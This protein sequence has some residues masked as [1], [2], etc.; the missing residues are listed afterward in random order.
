MADAPVSIVIP[1]FN[2][3]AYCQACVASLRRCTPRPVK[4]ILVDNGSTDGVGPFFDSVAGAEAV[5]AL[6]NR[7]FAGGVNLGLER[8]E[9]HVVLLNSDTLLTPGWLDRL[10]SALLSAPDIGVAGPMSNC[11]AGRQQIDG[12]RLRDETEVDAFAL[13]LARRKA[14]SV[15]EVTRLVGFCLM[16]REEAWRKVGPFDERFGIGNF[17]D[18]DYGTRMRRAGYRLVVAEDSFVFHHG[19]RTFAGMGLEGV[20]FER[21]LEENRRKYMEKWD[22]HVPEALSGARRAAHLNEEARHALENG[23]PGQAMRLLRAAIEACPDEARHYNDLGSILWQANKHELA[24]ELF[25]QALKQD[26]ACEEARRNARSAAEGLGRSQ[27]LDAWLNGVN[28]A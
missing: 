27:E 11:A 5:H 20:P 24:Y 2:Q 16:L 9:G 7:G 25:V 17:E 12:L 19:G 23:D 14:A 3:V 21:L 15:L 22:V 28:G 4:L 6:S 1:A 26:P 10:E 13:E 8:A 18:D